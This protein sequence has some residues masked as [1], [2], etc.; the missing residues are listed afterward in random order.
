MI[1]LYILLVLFI[2][3][4]LFTGNYF[5]NIALNPN[6]S[7]KYIIRNVT[8]EDQQN[9]IKDN[10]Y[11]KQWLKEFGEEIDIVSSDNFRLHGYK[12]ENPIKKSN[13]WVI[14]VHGY[15]GCSY[16][17]V[18]Y[19]E[20]FINLGFNTWLV[21]LRAHGK[22]EGKY[23]G[24][25]WEDKNDLLL[26]IDRICKEY[27]NCKIILYGMSMGAATVMMTCGEELPINVKCVV[28]DCGYSSVSKQ[29]RKMLNSVNPII[30]KYILVSA[31]LVCKIKVG[32]GFK[33]ASCINQI[34]KSKI[35]ILFIHGEKDTFVPTEMLEEVYEA[36]LVPKE[37]IIVKDAGHT[38]S[39]KMQAQLYWNKVEK[40]ISCYI[41]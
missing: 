3:I 12:V 31:N 9:E 20:K 21:D 38:K 18:K 7:K 2:I 33:Q 15:M 22:S 35:P 25:G 4:T 34:K 5:C 41:N 1:V 13:I 19:A 10:I 28:E 6:V 16:E 8:I 26:W 14:L 37:K 23:I 24:M 17:M 11:G 39:S 36:A 40:F 27:K 29:F 30:A 32:Y